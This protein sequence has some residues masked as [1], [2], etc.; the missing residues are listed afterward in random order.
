VH[1]VG[2]CDLLHATR[3]G[4]GFPQYRALIGI[5]PGIVDWQDG[6]SPVVAAAFA[7]VGAAVRELLS[8]WGEL[9]AEE[10]A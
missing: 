9:P 4:G 8:R 7:A 6:P 5:Q 10:A 2:I 1:E 3:L